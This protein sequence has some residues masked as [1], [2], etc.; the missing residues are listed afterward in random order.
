MAVSVGGGRRE[1][2]IGRPDWQTYDSSFVMRG[3]KAARLGIG[4]GYKLFV[5]RQELNLLNGQSH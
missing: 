3:G 5:P 2:K 4:H 1:D